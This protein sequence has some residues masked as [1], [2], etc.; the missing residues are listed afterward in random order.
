M[1]GRLRGGGSLDMGA[2]APRPRPSPPVQLADWPTRLRCARPIRRDDGERTERGR[3]RR[4]EETAQGWEYIMNTQEDL[5]SP[6]KWSYK[7]LKEYL[8]QMEWNL[9]EDTRQQI[10]TV[11][12]HIE[13]ELHKQIKEELKHLYQEIEIIKK[14]KQ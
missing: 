11:K 8:R 5:E 7:E 4:W 9:K 13:N 3:K 1:C 10:Q 12:E 2:P 6:E 14:I